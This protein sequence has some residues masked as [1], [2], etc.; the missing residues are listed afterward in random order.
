[1]VFWSFLPVCTSVAAHAKGPWSAGGLSNASKPYLQTT[2]GCVLTPFL[3]KLVI[4]P[5]KSNTF[6]ATNHVASR[7]SPLQEA[8][9][10]NVLSCRPLSQNGPAHNHLWQ[11]SWL[12]PPFQPNPKNAK[13]PACG[14]RHTIRFALS[15]RSRLEAMG[16]G[17]RHQRQKKGLLGVGRGDQEGAA[18]ARRPALEYRGPPVGR[19]E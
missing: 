12:S 18:W 19:F 1:M 16:H 6:R 2:S 14:M 13:P 11:P 15:F 8:G 17:Q 5:T 7:T 9:P 3:D 4:P 10:P